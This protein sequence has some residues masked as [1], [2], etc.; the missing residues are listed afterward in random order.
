MSLVQPQSVGFKPSLSP[1]LAGHRRVPASSPLMQTFTYFEDV[2]GGAAAAEGAG[3]G[4][5]ADPPPQA[6]SASK[7]AP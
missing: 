6:L 2:K 5:G 3:A 1:G 4:A 7:R